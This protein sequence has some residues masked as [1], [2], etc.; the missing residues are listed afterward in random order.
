MKF[1]VFLLFS[2]TMV[3][4]QS[5]PQ[6]IERIGQ[7]VTPQAAATCP[8]P[9]VSCSQQYVGSRK[10][11]PAICTSFYNERS[12]FLARYSDGSVVVN[13]TAIDEAVDYMQDDSSARTPASTTPVVGKGR[14]ARR[15]QSHPRTEPVPPRTTEPRSQRGTDPELRRMFS[16]VSTNPQ[17]IQNMN[18]TLDLL[19][20]QLREQITQGVPTEQLNAQQTFLIAKL[21]H[22]TITFNYSEECQGYPFNASYSGVLNSLN[23]CPLLTHLSP[24]SY[25]PLLSHELGHMIDPCSF[26][27]NHAFSPEIARLSANENAQ[28][29]L[30]SRRI[31]QCVTDVAPAERTRFKEWAT[32]PSRMANQGLTIY[33]FE[34]DSG[35]NRS[36]VER[37]ERCG[38]VVAPQNPAP[39]TYDGTPYLSMISCVSQSYSQSHSP[40]AASTRISNATCDRS[41]KMMETIADYVGSSLTAR[42][43]NRAP[44]AI[45]AERRGNLPSFYSSVACGSSGDTSYLP[46][47]Q[48]MNLFLQPSAIQSAVGCD[49][50][51][52]QPMC[53]LPSTLTGQE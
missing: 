38:V 45:P 4:A 11:Q 20:A 3:Q 21:D 46:P 9:L 6:L 43:L 17:V 2:A 50:S 15:Q 30:L 36:I 34:P 12:A 52:L 5:L 37:L 28:K 7:P 18:R 8:D 27:D 13:P 24:E 48:R 25:L 16:N 26:F 1:S 19:K 47:D 10:I 42:V 39:L 35:G 53:P 29:A 49:P 14:S 31:D 22:M 40:I 33:R 32:S 23:M 41:T 44:S 51:G